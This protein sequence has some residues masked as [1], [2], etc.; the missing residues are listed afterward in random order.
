MTLERIVSETGR[1]EAVLIFS[2]STMPEG[3]SYARVQSVVIEK[4]TVTGYR[5][6][7]SA[8]RM[9]DGKEGVYILY[10]STVYFR[11]VEV[12]FE[13]DGYFI[14]AERDLSRE[15]ASEYLG[16]SDTVISRGKDLYDGKIIE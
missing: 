13:S 4:S 5:I 8:L 1:R 6:P 3:F 10:G 12:I 2:T 7:T 9:V 16:H 15:D 11:R 14:V